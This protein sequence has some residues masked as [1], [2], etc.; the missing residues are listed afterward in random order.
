[1]KMI[2]STPSTVAMNVEVENTILAGSWSPSQGTTGGNWQEVSEGVFYYTDGFGYYYPC[3]VENDQM[4]GYDRE[5]G[6][7]NAPEGW[8]F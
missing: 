5:K 6:S 7:Q 8:K 3:T 2:Y 4:T 1:M